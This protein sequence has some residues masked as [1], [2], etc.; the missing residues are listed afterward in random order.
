VALQ[1]LISDAYRMPIAGGPEW[2]RDPP[3]PPRAGETRFDV[4]ATIPPATPAAQVPL[5]L[6]TML[7]ERFT[8]A[9]HVETQ[10]REA[11]ALVHARADKRRGPQLTPSTQQCQVEIEAGPLRAPVRRVTADGQPVCSMMVGPAAIRGGGLTLGF[12]ANAMTGFAGRMVVDRTGLE[13]PFDFELRY[14][15]SAARGGGP[16]P[17]DDRPSIFVAVQEQLGLEL[18][19][20]TAAVEVLVID[21]VSLPTEN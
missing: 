14:A 2:I 12:L 17:S 18:E 15:P 6:R 7:A 9:V 20:T 3:G 5:M 16:P 1:Q 19:P 4:I 11:Y 8:L 21:R 13:G 10:E